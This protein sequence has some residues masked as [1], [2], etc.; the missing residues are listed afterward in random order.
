MQTAI[1]KHGTIAAATAA[2]V[3]A[4]P[5]LMEEY[6]PFEQAEK[7]EDIAI[8][9]I[10]FSHLLLCASIHLQKPQ[11]IIRPGSFVG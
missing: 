3:A 6:L 8:H 7:H 4:L 2:T 1:D 10:V 5:C 9:T 11:N